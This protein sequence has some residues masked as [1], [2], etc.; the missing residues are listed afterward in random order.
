MRKNRLTLESL[1]V[2]DA[3]DRK[4]SFAAA[5]ESLYR[6][7]SK[8]TYTIKKLE[9]DLGVALFRKKGRRSELTETGRH[10]LEEGRALLDAADRLVE[11]TQQLDRGWE[12]RLRLALD[13]V[14][15]F[16]VLAP[17]VSAFCESQPGTELHIR[18]EVLG[19]SWEAIRRQRVDLVIGA[20][21]EPVDRRHLETA[22]FRP[23]P[24]VLAVAPSHPLA[25]AGEPISEEALEPHRAIVVRDSS[26]EDPALTR[27]VTERRQRMVVSSIEQKIAAQAA[28]LGIGF[29]PLGRAQPLLERGDLVRVPTEEPIGDSSSLLVWRKGEAGRALN[30]FIEQLRGDDTG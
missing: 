6:V 22:P 12:P 17:A 20:P 11:A 3:I 1:E 4:G 30:W 18:E 28:G 5:A 19:G 8:I 15:D 21:D 7:P 14:F 23:I 27:R 29:L 9:D 16:N 25:Q 13:S 24:W 26:L 10:L 2:L